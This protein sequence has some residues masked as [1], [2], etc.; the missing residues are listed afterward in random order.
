MSQRDLT[1]RSVASPA[2]AAAPP[3]APASAAATTPASSAAAAAATPCALAVTAPLAVL[4]ATARV[5]RRL[6]L[7]R[8]FRLRL[9]PPCRAS[10]T[11]RRPVVARACRIAARR[12][13][14]QRAKPR[15]KHGAFS[16]LRDDVLDDEVALKLSRSG[17]EV[18]QRQRRVRVL[19]VGGAGQQRQAMLC[20]GA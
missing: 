1:H 4:C 8:F 15:G 5:I 18:R 19:C 14:V 17:F 10:S 9:R 2:P 3:A 6:A 16:L 13:L 7:L 12:A 20:A 11:A